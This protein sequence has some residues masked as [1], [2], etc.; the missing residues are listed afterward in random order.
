MDPVLK[1]ILLILDYYVWCIIIV[2]VMSWLTYAGVINTHNRFVSI[3]GNFLYRI[4]EPVLGRV[5]RW[6][7]SL[8]GMDISPVIV[9]LLIWLIQMY[10]EKILNAFY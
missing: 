9:I 3:V 10:I 1:L 8:G 2:A 5:R 6:V 7:P 4:T